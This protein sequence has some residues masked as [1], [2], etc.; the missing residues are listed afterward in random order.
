M[1][2]RI[3]HRLASAFGVQIL[4]IVGIGVLAQSGT[5]QLTGIARNLYQHQFSLADSL[6]EAGVNIVAMQRSIKDVV[7]A[8]DSITLEK[9]VADVDARERLVYER[10]NLVRER[11]LG[12]R[13]DFERAIKAF[14]DW[15]SVR[16]EVIRLSRAGQKEEAA[17]IS[18][19]LGAG[20]VA[21]INS[22]L[23]NLIDF[24][25]GDA[26]ALREKA[27]GTSAAIKW[28][29]IVTMLGAAVLGLAIASLTIRAIIRPVSGLTTAMRM[30]VEGNHAVEVPALRLVGEMGDLAMTVQALK[31][32]LIELERSR[33]MNELQKQA[34]EQES[35][36]YEHQLMRAI[37][38]LIEL[39]RELQRFSFVSSHDLQEPVRTIALFVRLLERNYGNQLDEAGKEY[40]ALTVNAATQLHQMI[41]DLLVLSRLDRRSDE[42]AVVDAGAACR[43]AVDNLSEMIADTGAVISVSTLPMIHA[44]PT[45]L[46][47]VFEHL[48]GNAIKFRRPDKAPR[49]HVDAAEA[50]GRWTFSVTDNGIGFDPDE[51][52]VFELFR[53]LHPHQGY[54]GTGVGLAICKRIIEHHN[55]H[56]WA[57]SR[58]G[59]GSVFRFT[60]P[61]WLPTDGALSRQDET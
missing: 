8:P 4:M 12:D 35:R 23:H 43:E 39:R 31:E 22:T 47:Q 46:V 40:L 50:N 7:L 13:N 1:N 55:G 36:R 51:Q 20:Q 17:K 14:T 59:A 11:G 29:V 34:L 25:H 28:T 48:V 45:Q 5:D 10:L 3:G 37:D 57:E 58:L 30:M 24:A 18:V 42:L 60:I 52:D 19:G 41:N 32:K 9:A 56:I 15:K 61:S 54:P 2:I 26:A 27:E 38:N 49:I 53:R 21:E 6:A 44:D 16:D 33:A